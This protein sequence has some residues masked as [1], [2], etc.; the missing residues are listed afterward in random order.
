MHLINTAIDG[1]LDLICILFF[2]FFPMK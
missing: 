1:T 2:L